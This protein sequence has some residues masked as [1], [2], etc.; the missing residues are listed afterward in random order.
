[1]V[2][3]VFSNFASS[4][5]LDVCGNMLTSIAPVIIHDATAVFYVPL[6]A[7]TDAFQFATDDATINDV[8]AQDVKYY[9]MSDMSGTN[10]LHNVGNAMMNAGLS[11]NEISSVDSSGNTY[12]NNQ[13]LVKHDF[14]RYMALKLFNTSF[15]VDLFNNN[16]ELI[17]H[18]NTICGN[19]VGTYA[20][21]TIE[22]ALYNVC[23]QNSS[24]ADLTAD[25]NGLYYNTNT[26]NS[27]AN[28]CREMMLQLAN[29][30]PER[31]VV[32]TGLVT[33]T[34][35]PQPVPLDIGDSI[36]FLL[37]L[38]VATN[39][40]LLTGVAPIDPRI[41]QIKLIMSSDAD[42]ASLNTTATD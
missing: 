34:T 33:N 20:W 40:E 22:A 14:V 6:S 7:Y 3:I 11:A 16:A 12:A 41:Y 24:N 36:N 1:M 32:G 31:F 26:D 35:F 18:L 21:A 38:S 30:V 17:S 29:S 2:N 27:A 39:Q 10:I 5:Q 4:P 23:A 28:L 15:G 9:I 13:R 8:A 25:V 42:A 19:T 37:T